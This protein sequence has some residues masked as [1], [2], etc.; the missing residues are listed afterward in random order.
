MNGDSFDDLLIGAFSGDRP[1][2]STSL[3]GESY[4]IFGKASGFTDIDLTTLTP[5]QGFRIFGDDQFDASG[6]SVS[7]A[8]D[9]DGDGFDDLIIGAPGA[10]ASGNA[11]PYA[12]E[13]YV[14]FG[15]DFLSDGSFAGNSYGNFLTGTAAAE[16]FVG[17]QGNDMF[18]GNG[19]ADVFQGGEGND[20][21]V[22]DFSLA[23]VDGGTG[24]D[25]LFLLGSGASF[26]FTVLADN[27]IQSIET[28]DFYGSG[29]NTLTL[30]L[31]D[32]LNLTDGRNVDFTAI[33]S[34]PKVPDP[35]R[36]CRRR[37]QP[38]R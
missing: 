1:D 8:G 37:R 24:S 22:A 26:D 35:R 6:Y 32:V 20:T 25:S 15:G 27:K 17:G 33:T 4:V 34:V 30:G 14:L 3:A 29:D 31:T 11:V 2:N 10:S 18:E 23:K 19:G 16:T 7:S 12:G 21:I 9:I 36:K 38:R 13:S 28:L 5:D